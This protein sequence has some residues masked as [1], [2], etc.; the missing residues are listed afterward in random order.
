V[1]L[2]MSHMILEVAHVLF[3]IL[4][5]AFFLLGSFGKFDS[6]KMSFYSAI[7]SLGC[8]LAGIF[9]AHS[10]NLISYVVDPCF[11]SAF[12]LFALSAKRFI[13]KKL[14]KV[15]SKVQSDDR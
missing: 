2:T 7:A 8:M 15:S 14:G 4:A 10:A 3:M 11:V 1:K 12:V 13:A 5:A 9:G 6:S